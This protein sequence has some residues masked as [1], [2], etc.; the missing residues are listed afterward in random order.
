MVLR[1][2]ALTNQKAHF[3]VQPGLFRTSVCNHLL[4]VAGTPPMIAMNALMRVAAPAS[5]PA[6]KGGRNT[7]RNVASDTSAAL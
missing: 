7:S 3:M 4:P 5:T 2:E 6:L 1:K